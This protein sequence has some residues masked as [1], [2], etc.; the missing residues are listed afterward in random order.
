[1]LKKSLDLQNLQ[2]L[3][4]SVIPFVALF[5]AKVVSP[6]WEAATAY[7]PGKNANLTLPSGLQS[8]AYLVSHPQKRW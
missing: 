6:I 4:A 1:M 7:A 3:A 8:T 2:T 5:I